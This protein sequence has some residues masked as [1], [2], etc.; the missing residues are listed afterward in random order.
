MKVF[1]FSE[2][3]FNSKEWIVANSLV[4]AIQCL[5]KACDMYAEGNE[6]F[7]TVEVKQLTEQE[8]ES[9]KYDPDPEGTGEFNSERAIPFS[10]AIKDKSLVK[11]LPFLLSQP[12]SR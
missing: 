1:E 4:S 5:S 12:H 10:K 6:G 8:M 11:E 9:K 7:A 2:K 3:G